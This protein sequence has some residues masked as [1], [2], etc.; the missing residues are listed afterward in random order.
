[1][2][3]S[4][5]RKDLLLDLL[6]MDSCYSVLTL[7]NSWTYVKQGW[8]YKVWQPIMTCIWTF[9]NLVILCSMPLDVVCDH[10]KYTKN[11]FVT[12][13]EH[14]WAFYMCI[15]SIVSNY[16]RNTLRQTSNSYLEWSLQLMWSFWFINQ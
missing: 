13:R 1:M 12:N 10:F 8:C 4:Q 15:Q 2:D 5:R 14:F 11:C 16:F 6:I 3:C 9:W 7:E